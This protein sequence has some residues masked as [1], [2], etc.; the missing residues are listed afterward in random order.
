[1]TMNEH[2]EPKTA[3]ERAVELDAAADLA[4]AAA[5]R[6]PP[7]SA[8]RVAQLETE[9]AEANQH[10]LRTY[11]ELDN[12]RKRA[13]RLL[14]EET[15][16]APLPLMRDLLPVLD[17]LERAIQAADQSRD[18]AGL[19]EGVKMVAQQ[20]HAA[21][22][23]HH[24]VLIPTQDAPFDPHVHEAVA[25]VPHAQV[26]AGTIIETLS[27]GYRLH[28]RIVRPARVLVSA[29]APEATTPATHN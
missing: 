25:Q 7:I 6:S 29:G 27:T 17:N 21:L 13:Q 26:P 4:A 20:L 8:E 19:L 23:R 14:E 1:M 15:K 3:A 9:L 18:A 10:V 2:N 12:Y 11:A 28:D 5:G 22:E 16:Y 24:C